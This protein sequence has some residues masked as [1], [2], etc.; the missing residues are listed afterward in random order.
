MFNNLQATAQ[1]STTI[2]LEACLIPCAYIRNQHL[3]NTQIRLIQ[4]NTFT[5]KSMKSATLTHSKNPAYMTKT[6][7]VLYARLNHVE[8]RWWY[9]DGICAQRVGHRNTR[10][11]W[12]AN[13][14]RIKAA[15]PL[16]A[17]I[18]ILRDSR[19][20]KKTIMA[21]SG[22]QYK[23]PVD[24]CPADPIS[25]AESSHALCVLANLESILCSLDATQ[26]RCH[27]ASMSQKNTLNGLWK[28][29][30]V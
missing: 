11:I 26:P 7:L 29:Y 2:I 3:R 12:W 22:I 19:G 20:L 17:W 9:Q 18:L 10:D 15:Q 25:M 27:T 5:G 23:H 13:I 21:T 30:Y 4:R 1:A 6:R 28:L 16:S 24:H 14:T 8:P